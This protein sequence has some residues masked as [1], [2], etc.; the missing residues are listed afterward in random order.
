MRHRPHRRSLDLFRAPSRDRGNDSG[1]TSARWPVKYQRINPFSATDSRTRPTK[2]I[3]A[4]SE[5][6]YEHVYKCLEITFSYYL[7]PGKRITIITWLCL[8]RSIVKIDAC[9]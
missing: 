6:V 5:H 4:D 7:I 1:L 2:V 9:K 3:G 8:V